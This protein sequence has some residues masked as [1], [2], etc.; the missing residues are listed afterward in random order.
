MGV[1]RAG[2]GLLGGPERRA[3][4]GENGRGGISGVAALGCARISG[5]ALGGPRMPE[6]LP[7]RSG[8]CQM[9]L[10]RPESCR[11]PLGCH[12][13][14]RPAL[15]ARGGRGPLSGVSTREG[16]TS[17]PRTD[18][19]AHFQKSW[20]PLG[21][22]TAPWGSCQVRGALE[23]AP[24]R[25]GGSHIGVLGETTVGEGRRGLQ[26]PME[27]SRAQKSELMCPPTQVTSL[28]PES[29]LVQRR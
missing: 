27:K 11:S 29:Q 18:P 23:T 15:S 4:S 26:F 17:K 25:A 2:E 20:T 24:H 6:L 13:Q 21:C 9:G 12:P 10:L 3:P 16:S 8:V 7:L 22:L 5:G 28:S 1:P 14:R 19:T